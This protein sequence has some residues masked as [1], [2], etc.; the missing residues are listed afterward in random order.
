M[1]LLL[2]ED[3]LSIAESIL[4]GLDPLLFTTVHVVNGQEGIEQ[5]SVLNPDIILLD[6]GLPDID[7]TDVCRAI[8]ATSQIPIIVL[9]ARGS[10]IDRVLALEMGADDYMVKPF[11]MRELIARIKAVSRRT[12]KQEEASPSKEPR[13][14]GELSID[15]RSRR[16]YLRG[17]EVNLTAKEFDL[18]EYL[19]A[20]PERVHKRMDIL[21]DVW[22]TN[23]YGTTKTLD[24]HVASLRKKLGDARWVESVRGVGFR[25]GVPE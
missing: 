14:I 25:F 6:L 16:V 17:K 20:E 13:V 22:D 2:V 23:W 15:D 19:S 8:R 7:G 12:H 21:Q 10:E 4:D 3:D 24:A 9:S 11:G 18:L 5:A 1:Q